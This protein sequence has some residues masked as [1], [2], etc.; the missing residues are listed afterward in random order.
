MNTA[1]FA[2][3]FVL[4]AFFLFCLLRRLS[5]K[6]DSPSGPGVKKITTLF[7]PH[8]LTA[9]STGPPIPIV[10]HSVKAD[11]KLLWDVNPS[12]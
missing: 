9:T 7:E 8:R 2:W 1:S 4:F 11:K 10:V 12:A 6:V 3:H 5:E